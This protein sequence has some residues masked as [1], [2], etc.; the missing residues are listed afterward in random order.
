VFEGEAVL[1]RKL[2]NMEK[3]EDKLKEFDTE[4]LGWRSERNADQ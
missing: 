2:Q 1:G 4:E 3:G